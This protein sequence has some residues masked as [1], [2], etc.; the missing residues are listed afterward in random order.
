[1]PAAHLGLIP[2]MRPSVAAAAQPPADPADSLIAFLRRPVP[3]AIKPLL[4]CFGA[5][6]VVRY[7]VS[8]SDGT[9]FTVARRYREWRA[10]YQNLPKATRET[11][12]EFPPKQFTCPFFCTLAVAPFDADLV[13]QRTQM[14][15]Q[16]AIALLGVAR[17]LPDVQQFF[18]NF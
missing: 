9:T 8:S 14:L 2:V 17:H 6:G 11:L 3:S 13:E 1:M 7:L 4:P 15:Q 10:L 12:P 18:L 16:W 5:D